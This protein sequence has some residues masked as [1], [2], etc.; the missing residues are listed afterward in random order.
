MLPQKPKGD[1]A[2]IADRIM[3]ITSVKVLLTGND[4]SGNGS[5]VKA[6]VSIVIDGS[7]VM[8][9]IS[10]VQKKSTSDLLVLMPVRK[11]PN[12]KIS[13]YYHPISKSARAEMIRVVL[14]A[15]RKVLDHPEEN[16]VWYDK[17]VSLPKISH[18]RIDEIPDDRLV[19]AVVTV[20]LDDA[21]ALNQIRIICNS[22]TNKTWIAMPAKKTTNEDPKKKG[23]TLY[24]EYFHPISK[25]FRTVMTDS[26]LSAF[27]DLRKAI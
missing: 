1:K 22:E 6:S 16:I 5:S 9:G 23:E 14:D 26:I 2:I 13:E 3:K 12:G 11:K 19:K 15:Y 4:N 24:L 7:F 18:I 27:Q 10:V 8:R 17:E 21:F 25:E 20:I